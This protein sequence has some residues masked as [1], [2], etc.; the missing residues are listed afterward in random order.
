MTIPLIIMLSLIAACGVLFLIAK[1]QVRRADKAEHQ[2]ASYYEAYQKMSL[3]AESLEKVI[4]KNK[5]MEVQ[6][7]AE[8]KELA[9]TSDTDLV[10]R[11][12]GLF[13]GVHDDLSEKRTGNRSGP[14]RTGTADTSCPSHGIG[15]LCG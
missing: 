2:A 13:G 9:K 6:T 14:G 3:R 1:A 10:H 4:Q 12:N 15:T 5:K 11:A 8:R 7:N